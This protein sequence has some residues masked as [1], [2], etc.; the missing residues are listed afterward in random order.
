MTKYYCS[1]FDIQN[2]YVYG[3]GEMFKEELIDSKSI[4]YIPGSQ[5]KIEKAKEKYIPAFRRHFSNVGI[6]FDNEVLI[7]PEMNS[8]EV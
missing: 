8:Y 4:V 1:G 2:A 6:N 7:S 5:E 3:L